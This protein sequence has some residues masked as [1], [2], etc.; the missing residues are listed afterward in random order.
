V[1]FLANKKGDKYECEDCGL[2][3]L[4][5]EPCGCEPCEIVCCGTPMKPVAAAQKTKPKASSA[6]KP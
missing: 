2:V 3:L 4:V 6:K 1:L 5:D